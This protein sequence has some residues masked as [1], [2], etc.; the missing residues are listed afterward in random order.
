[1]GPGRRRSPT[2]I[3]GEPAAD[4]RGGRQAPA[5]GGGAETQGAG[6][7]AAEGVAAAAAAA[8]GGPAKA[9]AAAAAAAAGADEGKAARSPAGLAGVVGWWVDAAVPLAASCALSVGKC[10]C[11]GHLVNKI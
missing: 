2:S 11:C 8:A 4:G 10:D 6:P 1:M 9:A 7:A 5:G 3:R